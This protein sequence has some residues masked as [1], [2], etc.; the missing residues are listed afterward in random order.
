[1]MGIMGDYA[2]KAPRD[3]CIASKS[4]SHPTEI[5]DLFGK[6]L[7]VITETGDGQLLDEALVKEITGGDTLRGRRMREDFWEFRPTH[8]PLMV[9]NH[10]PSVRGVDNGIWRR[11]LVVPFSVVIPADKQDP[12]LGVK[13]KAEWPQILRWM[14]NGYLDYQAKG[15]YPPES[16]KVATSD[17]RSEM[18]SF[19]SFIDQCCT[20]D[21][22]LQSKKLYLKYKHWCE[23]HGEIPIGPKLFGSRISK[24][25]GV[26]SRRSNGSIY[27]GIGFNSR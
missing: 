10:R 8:L 13:L 6:R 11:L 23:D 2:I 19:G 4:K 25:P 12:E 14:V 5:A 18:D 27:E 24:L 3:F 21:P 17:Y 9:T 7:V 1:M 26:S 22:S 20:L 16:V 15:L